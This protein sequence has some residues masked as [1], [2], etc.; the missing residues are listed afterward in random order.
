MFYQQPFMASWRAI[1]GR[2]MLQKII[3]HCE[4]DGYVTYY[5]QNKT[6]RN[7]FNK[8]EPLMTFSCAAKRKHGK[9]L[10]KEN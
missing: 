5:F 3:L 4:T 2:A 9:I 1:L 10:V 8:H 7:C 6:R